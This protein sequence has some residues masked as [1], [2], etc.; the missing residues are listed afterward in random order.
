MEIAIREQD[1]VIIRHFSG[2]V[3]IRDMIES[4]HLLFNKYTDL[5]D[6]KGIMTNYL[7][8]EIKKED[9][10]LNDLVDCLKSYMDLIKD[11]KI[12]FVM[13][14]PRITNTIILAKRMKSLQIKP[15]TTEEAAMQ[16]LGE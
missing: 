6:Y 15:F 11:L 16:W 10:N 2:E 9:R 3:Y 14:T 8:A 1:G 7:D 4:W 13:D 12:A 5:R